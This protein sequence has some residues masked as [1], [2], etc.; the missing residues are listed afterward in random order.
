MISVVTALSITTSGATITWTTDEA[1]DSQVD[2][3]LTTAYGS[4]SALNTTKVTSHSVAL[5]GMSGNTTYHY[6]VR[7]R[8]AAGNLALS[9]DFSLTTLAGD[10]TSPTVAISAPS[11][12]ATVGGI[13]TVTANASDNVGVAGV[14]FKLDG[15]P[16][17][18]EDM[19][20]PYSISWNTQGSADLVFGVSKV[21]VGGM[22][23]SAGSGFSKRLSV[24][25]PSCS[26]DDIASE[27]KI[28]LSAGQTAATF[29]FNVAAHYLAQMAAFKT[30]SARHGQVRARIDELKRA[31]EA[32]N[33]KF[34][35]ED[36]SKSVTLV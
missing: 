13:V 17:G 27:D 1:S 12:G 3:G 14:Q 15:A 36:A 26:G 18:A 7:S 23:M 29:T 21:V 4:T 22:V 8:D 10:T 11:A 24:S 6:R 31:R 9:G 2:Y 25:C 34:L 28:Q 32:F 5:S 16:L 19:A 35:P 30:F 33:E 20:S